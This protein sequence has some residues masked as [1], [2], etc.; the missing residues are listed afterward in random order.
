[1]ERSRSAE[2]RSMLAR[3]GG[4]GAVFIPKCKGCGKL[5]ISRKEPCRCCSEEAK[6]NRKSYFAAL[7]AKKNAA[8]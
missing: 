4:M 5:S 8:S 7:R 3:S 6:E 1:M 2:M